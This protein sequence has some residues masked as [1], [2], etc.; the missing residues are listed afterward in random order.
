MS[1]CLRYCKLQRLQGRQQ[2]NHSACVRDQARHGWTAAAQCLG[3][4]A[5]AANAFAACLGLVCDH[6]SSARFPCC[7]WQRTGAVAASVDTNTDDRRQ[8]QVQQATA[9]RSPSVAQRSCVPLPAPP[10]DQESARRSTAPSAVTGPDPAPWARAPR[11]SRACRDGGPCDPAA[12][13]SNM[14]RM[15]GIGGPTGA[16]LPCTGGSGVRRAP[17]VAVPARTLRP[18]PIYT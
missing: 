15:P 11:V 18:C 8:L 10:A 3:Q 4:C 13:D 16:A 7:A 5:Y 14:V 6:A 1:F 9:D 12:S 2:S 17:G